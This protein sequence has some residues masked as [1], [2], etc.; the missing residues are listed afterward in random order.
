LVPEVLNPV[1][2]VLLLGGELVMINLGMLKL[3]HVQ[4]R[5]I[6][7]SGVERV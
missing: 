5:V 6:T 2:V 3:R 4:S 1:D 7:E